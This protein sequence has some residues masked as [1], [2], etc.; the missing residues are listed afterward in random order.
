MRCRRGPWT[1]RFRTLSRSKS[2]AASALRSK[3]VVTVTYL[4]TLDRV[5]TV[6]EFYSLRT[7]HFGRRLHIFDFHCFL[8]GH[9][10]PESYLELSWLW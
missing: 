6:D 10:S 1:R 5:W 4:G 9:E 3:S 7:K 8:L 2:C